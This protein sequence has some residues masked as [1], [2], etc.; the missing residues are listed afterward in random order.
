MTG[1]FVQSLFGGTVDK[2]N[3]HVKTDV[4]VGLLSRH[5][6]VAKFGSVKNS[7]TGLALLITHF[8]KLPPLQ[9]RV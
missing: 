5:R 9:A 1:L 3:Q 8:W 6:P 4:V 7:R 2:E